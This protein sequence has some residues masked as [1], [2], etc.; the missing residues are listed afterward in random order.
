MIQRIKKSVMFRMILVSVFAFV[1]SAAF[2]DGAEVDRTNFVDYEECISLGPLEICIY[3]DGVETDVLTPSG[4]RNYNFVGTRGIETWLY[5]EPLQYTLYDVQTHRLWK[6]W[7]ES[8]Q[9]LH[10]YHND[11]EGPDTFDNGFICYSYEVDERVL[12]VNGE[13]RYAVDLSVGCEELYS[14]AFGGDG[15]CSCF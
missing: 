1:G 4:N 5:G 10:V 14:P 15:E 9:T 13:Y 2:A 11:V 8:D 6:N 7:S 12:L 3:V